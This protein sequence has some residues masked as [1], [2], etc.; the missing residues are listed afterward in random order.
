MPIQRK[1]KNKK[2]KK[3]R[4]PTDI[5]IDISAPGRASAARDVLPKLHSLM[6]MT[7]DTV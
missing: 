1:K 6:S 2:K 3:T 5:D 4:G 7:P